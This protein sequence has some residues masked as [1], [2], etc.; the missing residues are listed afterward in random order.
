MLHHGKAG[1]SPSSNTVLDIWSPCCREPEIVY[2]T[3]RIVK[4]QIPDDSHL[5]PATCCLKLLGIFL[6]LGYDLGLEPHLRQQHYRIVGFG[7]AF[8]EDVV[9]L[10]AFLI[11]TFAKMQVFIT[12][13]Q[14]A[15]QLNIMRRRHAKRFLTYHASQNGA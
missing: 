14:H 4:V 6:R 10:Y 3:E 15:R 1:L 8:F 12:I 2:D 9:K 13:R 11:H 5:Q 7:R